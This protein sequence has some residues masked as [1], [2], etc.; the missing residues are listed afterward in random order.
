MMPNNL[1]VGFNPSIFLT[2][3]TICT[4]LGI[5]AG[6]LTLILEKRRIKSDEQRMNSNLASLLIQEQLKGESDDAE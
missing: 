4:V 2:L 1:A 3:A 5:I 6:T